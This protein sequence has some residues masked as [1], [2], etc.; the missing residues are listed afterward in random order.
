ML[1]MTLVSFFPG[2]LTPQLEV[3]CISGADLLGQFDMLP[4]CITL[5]ISE[6]IWVL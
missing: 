3:K 2:C 5:K 6:C 1:V 4:H